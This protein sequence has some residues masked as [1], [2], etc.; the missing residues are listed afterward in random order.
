MGR[1]DIPYFDGI[2][3]L[4]ASNMFK[5]SELMH[6]ENACSPMIGTIQKRNGVL[7]LGTAVGGGAFTATDNSGIFFFSNERTIDNVTWEGTWATTTLY[8]VG[9][10]VQSGASTYRCLTQHTSGTFA[11]DLTAVR[12]VLDPV[13]RGLYR[14][15]TV[16]A[17][18]SI[19]YLN[20]LNE[21]VALTGGGTGLTAGKF[22]T[23]IGEDCIFLVNGV[24]KNRYI[25]VSD[26]IT[27]VTSDDTTGHLYRS[28]IAGVV[29]YYKN[30]IYLGDYIFNSVRYRTTYLSSSPPL[31]LLALVAQDPVAPYTSIEITEMKYVYT[32]APGNTLDVYR[33]EAKVATITVTA[34]NNMI[35]TCTTA[36]EGGYTTILASDQLYAAG[37]YA[38]SKQFRWSTNPSV[39]GIST[40]QYDSAKMPGNGNDEIKMM[41]NI[42]NMMVLASNSSL[43]VW[44]NY[45]LQSFDA[46]NGCVSKNGF[47]KSLGT[48]YYMHYTG[49]YA[50]TGAAPQLISSKVES[51][52]A[53]AT[54]SGLE[55]CAAGR[56]GKSIYF[57]IG[58]VTIYNPDGSVKKT[59]SKVMLEYSITQQN[60]FVHTNISAEQ[61]ATYIATDNPDRC[62]FTSNT[63]NF[64]VIELNS[65]TDDN[66]DP[67]Y[68]RADTSNICLSKQFETISYPTEIAVELERGSQ[69]KCLVSLDMGNYYELEGAA[70]KG[71]TVFKVTPENDAVGAVARCRNIR[72]SFRDFSKQLC[73]I[74]KAAVI[75]STSAE[76]EQQKADALNV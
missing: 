23:A 71:C 45:T 14:I 73:K 36:F 63:T 65:G 49:I 53:G 70:I 59:L 24:D 74:S 75:Y 42:N 62:I 29:N 55:S 34:V 5:T 48:L 9:D 39:T 72:I 51:Y 7:T 52:I 54:K 31:G 43:S 37:T 41:A 50:T 46:G 4:V 69:I 17:T 66:G 40:K 28:P 6:A 56:Q 1:I 13:N 12:W 44:N 76:F 8:H 3:S 58:D 35:M 67:I 38:G 19:Y 60:W 33:N 18:T 64:P 16:S 27:V 11:T 57:A 26:G 47:V 20:T 25:K 30:Q 2:N 21:W 32:T 68:F 15:S 10:F 61:F 22:D